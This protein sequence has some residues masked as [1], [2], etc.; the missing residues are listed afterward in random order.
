MLKPSYL[1][2][3]TVLHGKISV[4]PRRGRSMR[5]DAGP[6]VSYPCVCADGGVISNDQL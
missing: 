4:I 5:Q 1:F 3:C 2:Y 6:F